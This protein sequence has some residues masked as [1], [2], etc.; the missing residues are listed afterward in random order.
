MSSS[1]IVL[2]AWLS[3]TLN[4]S[5]TI[6]HNFFLFSWFRLNLAWV[7]IL[8]IIAGPWLNLSINSCTLVNLFTFL[9]LNSFTDVVCGVL[10]P[11]RRTF[12]FLVGVCVPVCGAVFPV[13]LLLCLL[14]IVVGVTCGALFPC[15][16]KVLWLGEVVVVG[17]VVQ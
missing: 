11:R 14:V 17:K 4:L 7:F 8:T 10:F 16:L 6:E 12:P 15:S 2:V 1:Q 13:G 9:F 3:A 5:S